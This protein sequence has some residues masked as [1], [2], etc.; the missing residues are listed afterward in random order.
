MISIHACSYFLSVFF[1]REKIEKY[2]TRQ[3]MFDLLV[4]LLREHLID[5]HVFIYFNL[6]PQFCKQSMNRVEINLVLKFQVIIF[7]IKAHFK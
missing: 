1:W 2:K 5:I 6:L 3:A 7:F 4:F